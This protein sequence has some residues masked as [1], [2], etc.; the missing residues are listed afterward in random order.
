MKQRK[1]P[2][3]AIYVF[4]PTQKPSTQNPYLR[5]HCLT[6]DAVEDDELFYD[7][8]TV[9]QKPS[10]I[11][12]YLDNNQVQKL[13]EPVL[14]GSEYALWIDKDNNV[15]KGPFE[16]WSDTMELI[17]TCTTVPIKAKPAE[18]TT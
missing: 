8:G 1:D 13:E 14:I 2:F 16:K 5:L 15:Y 3:Y 12:N 9:P 17:T 6:K 10:V 18:A 7:D 11:T 4:V